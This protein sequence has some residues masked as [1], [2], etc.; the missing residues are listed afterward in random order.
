MSD[1]DQL[2]AYLA[3]RDVP[4][5]RCGYNLRGVTEPVCP[6][7]EFSLTLE[8]HGR[9]V[10]R[11]RRVQRTLFLIPLSMAIAGSTWIAMWFHVFLQIGLTP[12]WSTT[13]VVQICAVATFSV[14]WIVLAIRSRHG[15]SARVVRALGMAFVAYALFQLV[16]MMVRFLM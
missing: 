12:L 2:R 6:E 16:M 5:P 10:D 3:E 7:C 15:G 8:L 14:V 9:N 13:T 4:C 1:A 11:D